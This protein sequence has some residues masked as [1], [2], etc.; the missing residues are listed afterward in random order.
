[1]ISKLNVGRHCL[2]A[3]LLEL[4]ELQS[5]ECIKYIVFPKSLWSYYPFSPHDII[6]GTHNGNCSNGKLFKIICYK[7][8]ETHLKDSSR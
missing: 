1:M 6:H 8:S 3:P 2:K 5:I 7:I 4:W